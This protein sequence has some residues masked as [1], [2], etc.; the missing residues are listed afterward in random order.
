MLTA[1]ILAAAVAL[2]ALVLLARIWWGNR[3]R[4][5]GARIVTCPE[6]EAPAVVQVDASY[7][8]RTAVAGDRVLRLSKCS[9][10]PEKEGCR[11]ECLDQIEAAPQDC[12][13][14]SM[15][16]AWYGGT[17]CAFCGKPFDHIE[18]TLHPPGVLT[19]DEKQVLAWDRIPLE[20]L[21]EALATHH[22]VCWD[23]LVIESVVRERPDLVTLRPPQSS[24]GSPGVRA[25]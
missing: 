3:L 21:P 6:N 18:W 13:A 1:S 14:R 15:I 2:L 23:C 20:T 7:A 11:Q 5:R 17:T 24:S 16:T 10:W 4:W 25:F 8:A 19:P 9:R 22:P 12:L